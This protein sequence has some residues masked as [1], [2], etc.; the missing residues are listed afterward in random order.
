MQT[1]KLIW[2]LVVVVVLAGCGQRGGGDT[3]IKKE[4]VYTGTEGIVMKM[5]NVPETVGQNEIFTAGLEVENKGAYPDDE[6][7]FKGYLALGLDGDHMEIKANG[8]RKDEWVYGKIGENINDKTVRFQVKGKTLDNPLGGLGVTVVTLN[9]RELRE[10]QSQYRDVDVLMT[11]CYRY[12]TKAVPTVCV[13]S[14][15]FNLVEKEKACEVEDI[16]LKDQGAPIAVT[17]IEPSMLYDDSGNIKPMFLITIENKG[18]GEVISTMEIVR[19]EKEKIKEVD[20]KVVIKYNDNII[21]KMC[22]SQGVDYTEF[23]SAF[24]T[25]K[26]RGTP[27]DCSPYSGVIRLKEDE[28]I[29]R[30]VLT[31]GI[32]E[33]ST[34]TT[35]LEITLDYGYMS[36]VSEK[37][38]VERR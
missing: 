32:V 16:K 27:L 20:G 23:N 22:T 33:G 21:Q 28:G 31:E 36:T 4:E 29:A 26:L 24:I 10:D 12:Q 37:V 18:D 25:V 17:N 1:K 13:D 35:P 11:A 30:C 6:D 5:F 15:Q 19:D 38:R 3:P 2:L 34:Y 7:N 14:S 8:W 9:A